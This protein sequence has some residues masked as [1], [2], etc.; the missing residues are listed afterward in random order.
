MGFLD[1]LGAL[2][3]SFRFTIEVPR[4]KYDVLLKCL[5][6]AA[7]QRGVVLGILSDLK[8]AR[9]RNLVRYT[10]RLARVAPEKFIP[11]LKEMGIDPIDLLTESVDEES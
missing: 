2:R 6:L 7:S 5:Q 10:I 1:G 4:D 9:D 8:I 11:A 3:T